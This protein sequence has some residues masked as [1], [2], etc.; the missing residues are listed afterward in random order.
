MIADVPVG[1]LLSGGVDSTAVL[2]CAA[3]RTDKE[4]SSYTVGFAGSGFA[5][6]RPYAKLAAQTFGSRHHD[7]TISAADFAEFLPQYVW[8]M[9]E[10]VCEPPAI[11]LYYVSKMARKYVKVL[12]SGEG[13]D[14]AF[15]GYNNYRS[16]I[17]LERLKHDL[18]CLEQR[19]VVGNLP[20]QFVGSFREAGQICAFNERDISPVL[21]QPHFNSVSVLRE[22]DRGAILDGL[23]TV[24]RQGIYG[25]AGPQAVF[26]SEE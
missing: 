17:W 7:M 25:G 3:E 13:G 23:H 20:P 1:V 6:E 4:I 22:R 19:N 14:E 21:L 15:A 8:H 5:D 12:L 9:E 26:S 24:D 18:A 16:I 10:P 11:A 2:S